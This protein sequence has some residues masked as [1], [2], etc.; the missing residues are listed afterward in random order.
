[1][2]DT[3]SYRQGDFYWN[4]LATTD[5]AK[6]KAFYGPLFGWAPRDVP[7]GEGMTYT[8]LRLGDEEIGALFQIGGEQMA[9]MPSHWSFYIYCD[10][11]DAATAAAKAQGA[12]VMMEPFDIPDVGR[13][14]TL[15]DPTGAVISFM[16]GGGHP[17]A[18]RLAGAPGSFSW[19]ELMTPD[20]AKAKA[21]YGSVIGYGQESVDMGGGMEYGMLK[22]GDQSVAGVFQM[23]GD[24]WAGIPPNWM[25]YVTVADCDA[26]VAKAKELG[27]T[28]KMGPDDVPGVGRFAVIADPTGGVFAVI[29]Y[30]AM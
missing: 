2:S 17:G 27:G 8:M 26:T 5:A 1:M 12:T 22:V 13:M 24:Q 10:D 14:S 21:F 29:T 9:G 11:V 4:E 6:A 15:T 25:G 23:V 16:K 3:P 20:A 7:M 18:A 28:V 30:T 19:W